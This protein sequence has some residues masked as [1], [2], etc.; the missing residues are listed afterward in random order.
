MKILYQSYDGS[1]W[2]TEA[3][4]RAHDEAHPEHVLAN[5]TPEEILAGIERRDLE[6]ADALERVGTKIARDRLAAGI[7]K[8][9]RKP[10]PAPT[11][12]ITGP[13]TEPDTETEPQSSISTGE[14]RSNPD[15]EPE[16]RAA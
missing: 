14:S 8:Y 15:D 7:R 9:D 3:D 5:R 6:I 11:L 10:A 16:E 4:S 2:P 13:R 12:A 1:V